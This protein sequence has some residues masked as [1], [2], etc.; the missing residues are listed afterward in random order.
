MAIE[1]EGIEFLIIGITIVMGFLANRIFDKTQVSQVI[2]L[3]LFGFLLGPVFGLLDVSSES[4]IVSILPFIASIALIFLLFDGGIEFDIFNLAKTIPKSMLFT[5]LVF[6]L[7][8]I[9][10]GGFTVIALGWEILHGLLLGAVVGGSSGAVVIALVE[11][12]HIKKETKSLL[13]VE[14]TLTDA[15]VIITAVVLIGLITAGT[16]PSVGSLV[17]LFLSSFT[18]AITLGIIA[19][20]IWIFLMNRFEMHLYSYMLMLALLFGLFSLTEMVHASGGIAV[21]VFGVIL[22]NAKKLGKIAKIEWVN[23]V[24]RTSRLFQEEVTFFVRTFFF[25]Y[26]GLLLSLNYFS[27]IVLG[28]SIAI[29]ALVVLG[30]FLIQK[31]ILPDIPRKDQGIVVTMMPRGL[32]AAVVA[33]LPLTA[34]IMIPLFQEFVF[35]TILL[36]NIAATVGVF[37]FGRKDDNG[38][39]EEPK[40]ENGKKDN[41]QAKN[42]KENHKKKK[43]SA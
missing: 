1:A 3:M 27:P 34:G 14:S 22:G 21:F 4:V 41:G 5:L 38:E 11:R 30:R 26:V 15:L 43:A 12:S 36:T 9:F 42:N 19:A 37:T 16:V 13:T 35:T 29:V 6:A 40:K 32:A 18:I 31:L 20:F 25:V 23:P 8:M 33:T 28:V 10:I 24:S 39:K 2:L 17:G 7:G